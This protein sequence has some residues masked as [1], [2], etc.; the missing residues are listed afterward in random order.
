MFSMGYGL[1]KVPKIL[2]ESLNKNREMEKCYFDVAKLE[3]LKRD[4]FFKMQKYVWIVS[5]L[6][7]REDKKNNSKHLNE[8]Q[9][10]RYNIPDQVWADFS[11][12][13]ISGFDYADSKYLIKPLTTR[14]LVKLNREVIKRVHLYQIANMSLDRAILKANHQKELR[15]AETNS[16]KQINSKYNK[17]YEKLYIFRL[18]PSLGIFLI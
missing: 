8:I 6:F 15:I 14:S 16:Y 18:F 7:Q 3:D 4:S 10:I 17:F 13:Y 2:W 5:Q 12:K 11:S 1:I 9:K